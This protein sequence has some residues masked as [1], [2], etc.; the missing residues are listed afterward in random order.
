[1]S[2]AVAAAA[3]T[4]TRRR[5]VVD[6]VLIAFFVHWWGRMYDPLLLARPP[7]WRMTIWI[8]VIFFGPFYVAALY[9]FLRRREWIRVPA[10]VWAGTMLANVLILMMEEAVGEHATDHLAVVLSANASWF[11]V[12]LLMIWRMRREPVF[13]SDASGPGGSVS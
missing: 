4:T 13:A 9:A 7:F 12:P 5:S 10:L 3:M 2:A 6:V 8:D 11:L 1:V